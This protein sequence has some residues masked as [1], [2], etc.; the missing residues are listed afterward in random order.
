MRFMKPK[1][2]VNILN[3]AKSAGTST[4]PLERFYLRNS[5]PL[6]ELAHNL[7]TFGED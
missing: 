7:Q 6:A 5:P 2:N 3:P 4:E 1:E